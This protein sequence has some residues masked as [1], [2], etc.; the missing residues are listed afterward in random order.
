MSVLVTRKMIF[1]HV[2][3]LVCCFAMTNRLALC[4]KHLV[5]NFPWLNEID[6]LLLG[7]W[8]VFHYSTLNQHVFTAL[9]SMQNESA[10][11]SESSSHSLAFTWCCL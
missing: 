2:V 1:F 11:T 3:S 5:A 6:T 4:F 9:R 10:L 8:K 7:L